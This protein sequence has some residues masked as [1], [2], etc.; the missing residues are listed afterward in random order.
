MA[1]SATD[2]WEKKILDHIFRDAALGLNATNVW[3]GLFPTATP[4]SDSAAGTEVS[5]NAY[6]RVACNRTS[7][8]TVWNAATGT[9]PALTDNSGTITF[10]TATGSWGTVTHFGIFDASTAGNLLYWADL[11][12]SKAVGNGDTASFAAGALDVTQ[13]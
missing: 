3:V 4:P 2:Y 7:G 11:T 10:P 12:A 5:G 8:S 9:S 13:D 6:A 1:G